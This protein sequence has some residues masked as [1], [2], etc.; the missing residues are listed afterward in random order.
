M[1]EQMGVVCPHI[2]CLVHGYAVSFSHEV[3]TLLLSGTEPVPPTPAFVLR[4]WNV[5]D[6]FMSVLNGL[7]GGKSGDVIVGV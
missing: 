6:A 2:P 4:V 3:Y 1:R 5:L 7:C